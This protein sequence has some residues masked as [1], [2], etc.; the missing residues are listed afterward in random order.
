MLKE[1]QTSGEHDVV[2]A[3]SWFSSSVLRISCSVLHEIRNADSDFGITGQIGI[4]GPIVMQFGITDRN[5]VRI[6]M[7]F[8]ITRNP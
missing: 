8:G 3:A 5:A 4:T 6:V 1:R 7:Q 2:P